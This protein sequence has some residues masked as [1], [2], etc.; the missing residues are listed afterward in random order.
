M[1]ASVVAQRPGIDFGSLNIN[2]VPPVPIPGISSGREA[3][4]A[5]RVRELEDELRAVRVE[6][7]RHVSFLLLLFVLYIVLTDL[8]VHRR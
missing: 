6:N 4:Y 3:Q 2:N 5:R 8:T 7:E 1:G